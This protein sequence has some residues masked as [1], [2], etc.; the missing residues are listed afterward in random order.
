[1]R[2]ALLLLM[3]VAIQAML[4]GHGCGGE[5]FEAVPDLVRPS[6]T[7]NAMAAEAHRWLQRIRRRAHDADN[8]RPARCIH[9]ERHRQG[10]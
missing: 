6:Y 8:S 1:M 5:F 2:A 9:A 3:A 10:R 7:L 4:S